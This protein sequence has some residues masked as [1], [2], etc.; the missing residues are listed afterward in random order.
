MPWRHAVKVAIAVGE[1]VAKALT[2]AIKN[3]LQQSQHAAA[4]YASRT[5]QSSSEARE[6]ADTNAKLGITL[7]ESLQ[8]LNIKPPIDKEA[9]EKNFQHLFSI[10]D[11][12]K[13]GS[14]Y[15]QSK[16]YR[17]KERIDEELQRQSFRAGNESNKDKGDQ[18]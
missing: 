18:G 4:R 17:A 8:I 7:E 2:R 15:L 3:E 6:S 12:A 13:G 9:V 14:F 11:K 1:A 16:I 10:N 5:N